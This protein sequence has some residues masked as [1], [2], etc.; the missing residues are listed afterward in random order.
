VSDAPRKLILRRA[1]VDE[2]IR[3]ARQ[4]RPAECCG[5]IG[6]HHEIA[7][8]VYRLRNV[9][10]NPLVAYEA[11]PEDL[12]AVQRR[13]R[14]RGEELIGIYHSHPCASDP[15]PSETDIR[16]AYYPAAVYLIIGFDGEEG[17]LRAF[18]LFEAEHRWEEA[19]YEVVE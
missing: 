7:T 3:H 19:V 6:G 14:V 11:A 10:R 8:S 16:L 2:I 13:M 9:A 18:H 1:H 5:L 17:I 15:I 4:E 12:F